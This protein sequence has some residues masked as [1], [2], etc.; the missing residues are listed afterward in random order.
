MGRNVA[1][2]TLT[3][4]GV[5]LLILWASEDPQTAKLIA[6]AGSFLLARVYWEVTRGPRR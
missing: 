3:L 4:S 5:I 6:G 2:L 1:V